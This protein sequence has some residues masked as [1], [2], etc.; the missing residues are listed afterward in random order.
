LCILRRSTLPEPL[1][2]IER[3]EWY[4]RRHPGAMRR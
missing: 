3:A 2:D 4:E 1:P